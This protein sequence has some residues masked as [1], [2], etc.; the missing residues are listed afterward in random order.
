MKNI[1]RFQR[2]IIVGFLTLNALAYAQ[3]NQFSASEK[4]VVVVATLV[5]ST[6]LVLLFSKRKTSKSKISINA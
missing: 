3:V 6:S 2:T 4:L 5:L 1:R